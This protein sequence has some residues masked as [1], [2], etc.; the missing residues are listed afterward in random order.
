[1]DVET[2]GPRALWAVFNRETG[3]MVERFGRHSSKAS[4]RMMLGEFLDSFDMDGRAG[5]EVR[6][7]IRPEENE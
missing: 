1:M 7:Q 3:D 2:R 4:A 5:F 6:Q